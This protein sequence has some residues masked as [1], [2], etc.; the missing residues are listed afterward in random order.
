MAPTFH[1]HPN[2]SVV[3][4]LGND[5]S[6]YTPE[7]DGIRAIAVLAVI[8]YHAGFSAF[9]GGYVGVDVFFVISG[10]LISGILFRAL[11][12]DS[13]SLLEFY[14]RRMRRILPAL[15]TVLL[16]CIPVSWQF[17]MPA[18]LNSFSNSLVA[19]TLFSANL[20]FWRLPTGYFGHDTDLMPLLHL[21][22][23][24]IE[25]QFYLLFPAAIIACWALG[26]RWILPAIVVAFS[27]SLLL[28]IATASLAPSAS[29]YFLPMR[30]WELLMGAILAHYGATRLRA[31][32]SER[33]KELLAIAG[34]ICIIL[35][36]VIVQKYIGFPWL[37]AFPVTIGTVLV[38]AFAPASPLVGGLLAW[39]PLVGV[40]LISYSAYL[41]HQP[42]FAFGRIIT[43]NAISTVHSLLLIGVAMLLAFLTWRFIETPF[44]NRTNFSRTQI[45][46][47]ASAAMGAL[48]AIGL[49]GWWTK[50]FPQRFAADDQVIAGMGL[51]Y[52]TEL[53]NCM[54]PVTAA[55]PSAKRCTAGGKQPPTIA[56][57][58]DSHA[59]ASASAL[60]DALKGR[61][62][63][64]ILFTHAAC[65]P[66]IND[67]VLVD[68]EYACGAYNRAALSSI[69]AD[70]KIHT[71]IIGARWTYYLKHTWFDNREGGI[72]AGPVETPS[73]SAQTKAMAF[74]FR[75]IV[76]RLIRDGR[77]V[78]LI[79]PI[80]EQ[81]WNVPDY[82]VMS[83]RLGRHVTEIS[84]S[85]AIFHERNAAS[86]AALDAIG[87][88]PQIT[89]LY[90]ARHLC[91]SFVKNRCATTQ[92][93]QPLYFDDN[94][95]S[96]TGA[97]VALP[98]LAQI[99]DDSR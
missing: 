10:Y 50:G 92:R 74:A 76:E 1:H 17:L 25:E 59:A 9:G 44:R 5:E 27:V 13:F 26:R 4:E 95:L 61:P 35:P 71:I 38:I 49:A 70:K 89:R 87:D 14:E 19:S 20:W 57:L 55:Q 16:I 12:K 80:P 86:Y 36:I 75:D 2:R 90:P 84:T 24:A 78:V 37:W 60:A 66:V 6:E 21:W 56:L 46:V 67:R 3:S 99:I 72:E 58:G 94:H 53:K 23:L 43:F 98:E 91:D 73:T 7:I 33:A 83:K 85:Y 88:F 96:R 22:S 39:R 68:D 65:P 81:G 62:Q 8:F 30:A 11:A 69:L 54:D 18:E 93:G 32:T 41:W 82:L 77:R 52:A 40:G 97:I 42:L 34:M 29:F 79:Y 48:L 45:F 28:Y 51:A 15:F 47:G 31:K 64:A 63:S